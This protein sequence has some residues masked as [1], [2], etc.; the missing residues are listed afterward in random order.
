[1]TDD[2][3]PLPITLT[4]LRVGQSSRGTFGVLRD[5]AV[6]FAVTME[7]PWTD[8]TPNESCIPSGR[9]ICRRIRSPKF[10]DTFEVTRVP[11]RTAILWHAGNTLE[12]TRGCIMV[13]EE[14]SGTYDHPM[15]V[16]SQRGFGEFMALLNGQNAF[17]L[18]IIQVPYDL[19]EWL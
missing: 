5:G 6:P 1:M 7:L 9:Y 18:D 4:L 15:I 14:F 10:G 11:N 19:T 12:D 16:S 13:G 2:R 17:N 3:P 8:N